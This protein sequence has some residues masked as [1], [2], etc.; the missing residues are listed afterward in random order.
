MADLLAKHDISVTPR[1]LINYEM[2]RTSP[3][4]AWMAKLKEAIKVD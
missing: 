2:G 4:V 1:T 3:T